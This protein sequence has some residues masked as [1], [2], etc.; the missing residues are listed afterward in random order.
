MRINSIEYYD[1]LQDW[2]LEPVIFEDFT[3]LIGASGVGKTLILNAIHKLKE[4]ASGASS[5]GLQ[6]KIQF[7]ADKNHRYTWEGA[8]EDSEKSVIQ[9]ERVIFNGNEIVNREKDKTLFM[10]AATPR[11]SKNESI[12][13]LLKEE[14]DIAPA[15]NAFKKILF[16]DY[17]TRQENALA[18]YIPFSTARKKK[19]LNSIEA[20]HKSE[21]G[22]PE[23][24]LYTF[25]NIPETFQKIKNVF[26]DIFPQ[27]KD[28]KIVEDYRISPL[29]S[30]SFYLLYFK[31]TGVDK[32]I[33]Q[34]R[35]SSGMFKT[36]MHIAELY[37]VPNGTL[38]L[39]D[40]FENSLGI[41]C[42]DA[43]ADTLMT[44]GRDIRFIVTSHH[45]YI[46]NSVNFKHWK[47][48]VRDAGVV[49]T[50]SPKELNLGESKHDAFIQLLNLEQFKNGIGLKE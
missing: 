40:E 21:I 46:I 11:L 23:K 17:T 2:R 39:I 1:R 50:L 28:I 3:L 9:Y 32:W 47:V 41:N 14:N 44:A 45:P 31:E 49:K 35:I 26:C 19:K 15:Y 7:E 34:S 43:L 10:G 8:F 38:F 37:L 25:W 33:H 42:M 20:I 48:V 27:V 22:I 4:I 18:H 13:G 30:N 5:I 6:W 36:F 24:L 12:I 29:D 16:T